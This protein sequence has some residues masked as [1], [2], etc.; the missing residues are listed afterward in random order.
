MTATRL[1]TL[2]AVA[3]VAA[4]LGYLL[5]ELLYFDL[6]P[7]PKLAPISLAL[8]AVAELG[9]AKAVR[10]W[11]AG[12]YRGRG[13]DALQ[14]ARAVVL[15]KASSLAGSALVGLYAG[16]FTWTVARKDT[17]ATAGPDALVAGLSGVAALL[18]V[19]SALVL[20]RACRTPTLD[21]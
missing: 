16:V 7:L 8:V 15:A 4:L 1:R 17:L 6:P 19:I 3:V 21:E 14:V 10:D 18:L 5:T 9:A 12:T 13:V 2:L 20:E 11:V